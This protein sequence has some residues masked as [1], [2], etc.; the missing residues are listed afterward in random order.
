M[1]A[2]MCPIC[3]GDGDVS[4]PRRCLSCG[5]T[6]RYPSPPPDSVVQ[7]DDERLAPLR[8]WFQ[9][10][11]DRA[12]R[13]WGCLGP[14]AAR[15]EANL[16]RRHLT[17]RLAAYIG[18]ELRRMGAPDATPVDCYLPAATA[19]VTELLGAET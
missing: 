5:G 14:M 18:V 3:E 1:S 19:A 17:L 2:G 4:V 15:H 8:G 10:Q 16:D 11:N 6:G 9:E 7:S 13:T 12:M